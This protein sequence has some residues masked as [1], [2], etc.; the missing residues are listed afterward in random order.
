MIQITLPD[1]SIKSFAQATTP[2]DVAKSISEG[3]ARNI[4]SANFNGTTVEITT[5]LNSD[6]TLVLYTWQD[7]RR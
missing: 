2:Y 6:G 4:I 5:P 3:L 7:K 1:G